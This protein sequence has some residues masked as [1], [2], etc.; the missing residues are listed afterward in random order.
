MIADNVNV[1]DTVNDNVNDNENDIIKEETTTAVVPVKK[2]SII[3]KQNK[4]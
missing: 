4:P 2:K 1:N 3:N